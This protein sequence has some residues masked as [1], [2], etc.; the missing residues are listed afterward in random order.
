M[1]GGAVLYPPVTL[2]YSLADCFIIGLRDAGGTL[3][4][5]P[6]GPKMT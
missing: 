2:G 6:Q 5:L 3:G 4:M 1:G